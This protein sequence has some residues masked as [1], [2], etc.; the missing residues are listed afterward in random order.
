LLVGRGRG[1]SVG[2]FVLFRQSVA[3]VL[4]LGLTLGFDVLVLVVNND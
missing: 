3:I 4:L 2:G 1:R